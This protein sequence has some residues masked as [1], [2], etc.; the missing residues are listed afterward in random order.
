MTS[1]SDHIAAELRRRIKAGEIQSGERVPSTR[2]IA[3]EWGVAIATAT[4]A[5][6][7]LRKD[8]LAEP[9]RGVGTVVAMSDSPRE[10]TTQAAPAR[11]PLH[12]DEEV[13][14]EM[15]VR[16]AIDL[17]DTEGVAALSM[18]HIASRL[19]LATMS[20]YRYVPSKDELVLAMMDATFAEA[21]LPDPPRT[22]WRAQLELIARTQWAGYQRHPWVAAHVS[23]TRPQV[24][25][26]GVAYTER[27]LQA[28]D[29]L[30]LDPT[31]ML[32]IVV[33]LFSFVRGIAAS[34]ESEVEAEQDTGMNIDEWIESQSEAMIAMFA[35]GSYPM[36]TRI[37]KE[38]IDLDLN[39]LFEFG[40][41]R[42]LDGFGTL[43]GL[44][45][46]S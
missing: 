42:L 11:R 3:R 45:Q 15:I 46:R 38:T 6:A 10:R 34:L 2:Q 8:G 9:V 25:P 29:G 5:L 14:R 31:A 21:K 40:L 26:N 39:T 35:S 12:S 43:I 27:A 7:T 23:M 41:A 24:L 30:G 19:G 33:C 37:T 32:H 20:L 16:A 13:T 18:R 1:R 22:G 17:A 28:L 36:T 4:R 44:K